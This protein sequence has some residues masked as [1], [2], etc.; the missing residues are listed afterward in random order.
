LKEAKE[1]AE[2][3]FT[4]IVKPKKNGKKVQSVEEVKVVDT[5]KQKPKNSIF[6]LEV[7]KS[8]H[9]QTAGDVCGYFV[10]KIENDPEAFFIGLF[11][12]YEHTKA[13]NGNIAPDIKDAKLV[14]FCFGKHIPAPDIL[15]MR[16][17]S[18]GVLDMGDKFIVNFQEAPMPAM[19]DIMISWTKA[20]NA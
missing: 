1:T 11:D 3:G 4:N 15:A 10:S 2:H 14:V 9:Y 6:S 16:P 17:R 18:F 20:L 5:K 7:N 8:S 12:H 13:I 19:R